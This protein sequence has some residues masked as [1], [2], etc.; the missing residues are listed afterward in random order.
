MLNQVVLVGKVSKLDKQ[1]GIVLVH[2]NRA[3][4]KDSDLIPVKLNEILMDNVLEY[5]IEGAIIGVKASLNIDDD[6]LRI[7][8]EKVTFINTKK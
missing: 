3:N 5:L 7:V 6:I 8:A 4:N 1:A 2:I